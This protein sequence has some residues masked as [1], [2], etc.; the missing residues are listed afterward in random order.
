MKRRNKQR[1]GGQHVPDLKHTGRRGFLQLAGGVALAL[2]A[3]EY[4]HGKAWADNAA[5]PCRFLTVF[6]HGGTLS[7]MNKRAP[8]SRSNGP[9]GGV[10]AN[11]LWRMPA[12]SGPRNQTERL[13]LG[14]LLVAAGFEPL[15][16]KLVQV[17]GLTNR[18]ANVKV[19]IGAHGAANRSALTC[20][21]VQ[22]GTEPNGKA[23]YGAAGPSI[24]VVLAQ[25][26]GTPPMHLRIAD[27]GYGTPYH[28]AARSG[29]SSESSPAAAFVDWFD[30]ITPSTEAPDPAVLRQRQR[31]RLL[32]DGVREGIGAYRGRVSARD[33]HVIDAHLEHINTLAT[34]LDAQGEVSAMCSLPTDLTEHSGHG[35]F[36]GNV[37]GPMHVRLMIAAIRCGLTRVANL[38][39]LDLVTMWQSGHGAFGDLGHSLSKKQRSI[40]GTSSEAAWLAEMKENRVWRLGLLRQ[41]LEGLNDPDF[42]EGDR[43]ILD[44]SLVLWTS[45]FSE[46]ANHLI[47][48]QPVL[49]AGGAGGRMQT[50][51]HHEFNAPA[52][53]DP[54]TRAYETQYTTHN[55]FTSIL[56]A[57]GQEDGHFGDETAWRQGPLPGLVS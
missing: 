20:A 40:A 51:L 7:N 37:T 41:L 53:T 8:I 14:E 32:L 2:P 18:A 29:I 23:V 19:G 25:R 1:I 44:N 48:N 24:D 52:V 11:D 35:R 6:S 39:I 30:G 15:R 36:T 3:L 22:T 57:F 17:E 46:A 47:Y 16:D 4:T 5:A 38:E 34:E 45:E 26:L 28:R 10:S 55:L 49:M 43:T 27:H 9:T 13:A 54:S 50:G 31:R 56:H 21:L 12:M 33:L 42:M